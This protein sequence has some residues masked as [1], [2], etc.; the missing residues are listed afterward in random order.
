MQTDPN[1]ANYLF[2]A[3]SGRIALLDFGAAQVVPPPLVEVL[4]EMGRALRDQDRDKVRATARDVGFI[5][6]RD[7]EAQ[8]AG[9]VDLMLL[10]SEPLRHAGPYDFG[11]SDLFGRAYTNGREQYMDNGFASAP[12]ADILLLQRKLA[13]VFMLAAR[14]RARIDIGRL[15]A[16]YL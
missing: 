6:E 9:V 13:G 7:S 11:H 4:R 2:D 5:G 12:P 16:P 10:C 8:A 14:L 3:D 15:F 1:F